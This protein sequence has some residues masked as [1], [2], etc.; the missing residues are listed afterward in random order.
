MNRK[1]ATFRV[2]F[3]GE[4]DLAARALAVSAML[5]RNGDSLDLDS[6]RE[7]D[8]NRVAHYTSIRRTKLGWRVAIKRSPDERATSTVYPDPF[9]AASAA[10]AA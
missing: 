1:Q 9:T 6:V 4:A 7:T 2:T 3:A 5:L 10:V 8:G